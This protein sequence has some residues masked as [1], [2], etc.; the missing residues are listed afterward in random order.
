ML[1]DIKEEYENKNWMY[2]EITYGLTGALLAE[3]N[4]FIASTSR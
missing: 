2:E 4:H 1:N 3:L